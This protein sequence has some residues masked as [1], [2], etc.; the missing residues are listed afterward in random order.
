M[1]VPPK[2]SSKFHSQT[3]LQT[4]SGNQICSFRH[5]RRSLLCH[6]ASER[7][8]VCAFRHHFCQAPSRRLSLSSVLHFLLQVNGGK[9]RQ[10]ERL[11]LEHLP[12][13]QRF[14]FPL[15]VSD[16]FELKE[17]GR[18][19][20]VLLTGIWGLKGT[21]M[22]QLLSSYHYWLLLILIFLGGFGVLFRTKAGDLGTVPGISFLLGTPT[23][24]NKI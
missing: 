13:L 10:R 11:E 12:F 21:I 9:T 17:K 2:F 4:P 23:T 18:I 6:R 16:L 22:G 14:Y 24:P 1:Q 5:T 7:T 20:T 3:R 15:S 8:Q 19:S